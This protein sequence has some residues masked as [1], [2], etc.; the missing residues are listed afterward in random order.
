MRFNGYRSMNDNTV[1]SV[2][3]QT[4]K[5][6][7]LV[8]ARKV[9]SS[10]IEGLKA[11][12]GAL[13]EDFISALDILTEI[14]GRVAVTGIGK[15]GH[16]AR[17]I[18]ATLASTGTPAFFVHP[19]EASHGDLGMITKND[20]LFAISNSGNTPELTDLIRYATQLKIPLI[21]VTSRKKSELGNAANISIILPKNVEAC[22]MGL[23]P[24]TSTT[25]ALALGDAIAIALLERKNF[26]SENFQTFHPGGKLGQQLLK[27]RDIMH[28]GDKIPLISRNA[29]MS[30][31]IIEM[32]SK[33]LG[34]IG[35][36]EKNK[37]LIGVITD[38]DLRRHMGDNILQSR[39][40]EIMTPDAKTINSETL[41]SEALNRMNS[42]KITNFFVVK[43][44]IPIGVVH[45]HDCISVGIA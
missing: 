23:A 44:N 40:D 38:G 24:T 39:V 6:K 42:E 28:I 21:A 41:A 4:Y 14:T 9:I 34:C 11:L 29:L 25:M 20:A 7:D 16:V 36:I 8:L 31:A 37:K 15:S 3:D 13:G 43:D 10:E 26:T 17:K 27:V 33:R 5:S 18:A 1:V 12:S 19:A 45:I 2:F 35:V 22:S 30:E 32:T